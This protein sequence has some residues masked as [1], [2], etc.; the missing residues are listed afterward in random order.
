M[1]LFSYSEKESKLAQKVYK[2]LENYIVSE[3]G[4]FD[5][6][7]ATQNTNV[8]ELVQHLIVNARNQIEFSKQIKTYKF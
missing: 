6:S 8:T 2:L 3:C 4:E 5:T 7:Y 1:E